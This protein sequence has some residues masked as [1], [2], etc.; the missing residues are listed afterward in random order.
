MGVRS[1]AEVDGGPAAGMGRAFDPAGGTSESFAALN[2][3]LIEDGLLIDVARGARMDDI[4]HVVF[5]A[6]SG[7]PLLRS[8][9]IVVRMAEDASLRLLEEYVGEH[10]DRGLTNIVTDIELAAG[11]ILHHH[12]VQNEAVTAAH[13]GRVQVR[14]L[15]P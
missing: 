5:V 4:L 14:Q 11:N 13:I 9:R 3:A 12:R 10:E 15:G 8:V 6:T 7:E 2:E 1:L